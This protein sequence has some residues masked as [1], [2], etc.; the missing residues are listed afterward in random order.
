MVENNNGWNQ[1]SSSEDRKR[2]IESSG[3]IIWKNLKIGS[4]SKAGGLELTKDIL[5]CL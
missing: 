4:D 1:H 2:L 3:K 5:T